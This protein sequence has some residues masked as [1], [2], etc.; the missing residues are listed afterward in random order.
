MYGNYGNGS[1]RRIIIR[2]IRPK[3]TRYQMHL[4]FFSFQALPSIAPREDVSRLAQVIV[5][6]L[7][8]HLLVQLHTYITL[9][10]GGNNVGCNLEDPLQVSQLTFRS[11]SMVNVN[12]LK[13][14]V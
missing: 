12:R 2:Q 5:W 8:H 10:L 11:W 6:C 4:N 14:S 1:T 7:Q 13:W 9:C 3:R